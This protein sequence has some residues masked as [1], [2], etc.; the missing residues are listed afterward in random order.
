MDAPENIITPVTTATQER[1]FPQ[2]RPQLLTLFVAVRNSS[3]ELLLGPQ[4]YKTR[5]EAYSYV[6]SV[7]GGRGVVVLAAGNVS[8][9]LVK[10]KQEAA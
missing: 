9:E 2:E 1:L 3:G 5:A 10:Y 4:T 7:L 6:Q 8:L